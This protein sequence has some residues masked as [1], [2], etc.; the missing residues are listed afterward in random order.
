MCP[1][2]RESG[3]HNEVDGHALSVDVLH[4]RV[5][6]QVHNSKQVTKK[7]LYS[8]GIISLLE[9]KSRVTALQWHLSIDSAVQR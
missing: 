3:A 5:T 2:V 7:S 1:T 9:R 4:D 6:E 8:H